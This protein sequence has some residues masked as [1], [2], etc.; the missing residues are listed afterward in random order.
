MGACGVA[1]YAMCKLLRR[2]GSQPKLVMS[3]GPFPGSRHCWTEVDGFIVDLTAT[4]FGY[5]KP[6]Q[7]VTRRSEWHTPWLCE[8]RDALER[9]KTWDLQ[10]PL[11][12][13]EAID[14]AVSRVLTPR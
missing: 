10:N 8:G 5:T 1:A 13:R 6:V 4:Q 9:L 14:A 2:L 12:H 11:K 7:V 3:G